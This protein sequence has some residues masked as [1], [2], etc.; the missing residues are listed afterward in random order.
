ML[1]VV[2]GDGRFRLQALH[3]RLKSGQIEA[4]RGAQ[5]WLIAE[6][7]IVMSG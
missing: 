4:L 7:R 3:R 6:I 2:R 5:I 1:E